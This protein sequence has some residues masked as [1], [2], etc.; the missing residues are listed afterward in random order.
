MECKQNVKHQKSII[1]SMVYENTSVIQKDE[2]LILME[3][4]YFASILFTV[5]RRYYQ[6]R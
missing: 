2:H 1:L 6:Y 5:S 4:I 3:E